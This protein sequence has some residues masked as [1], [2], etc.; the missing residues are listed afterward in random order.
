M[1][2]QLQQMPFENCFFVSKTYPKLM[3]KL[4]ILIHH[5]KKAY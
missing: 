1:K 5:P 2:F 4:F 3:F